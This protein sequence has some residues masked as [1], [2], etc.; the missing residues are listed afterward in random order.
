MVEMVIERVESIV[1]KYWW[2]AIPI[3]IVIKN[4][5]FLLKG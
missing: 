2:K 5:E 1:I 3:N 4:K